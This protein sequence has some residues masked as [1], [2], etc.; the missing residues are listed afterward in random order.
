MLQIVDTN[1]ISMQA[2]YDAQIVNIDF[3][4]NQTQLLMGAYEITRTAPLASF[5][6]K[7][8]GA[9]G[10]HYDAVKL[11]HVQEISSH[12]HSMSGKYGWF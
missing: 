8:D 3:Y 4:Q 12:E 6:G 11:G 2:V 1:N 9:N 5:S 7:F 10:M